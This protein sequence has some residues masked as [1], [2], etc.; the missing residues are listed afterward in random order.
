EPGIGRVTD[1]ESC[2]ACCC[3]GEGTAF[4]GIVLWWAGRSGGAC[5]TAPA[6]RRAVAVRASCEASLRRYEPDQVRRVCLNHAMQA[7]VPPL[8]AALEHSAIDPVTGRS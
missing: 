1:P 8:R 7:A 5:C 3:R 2:W 6:N 4:I